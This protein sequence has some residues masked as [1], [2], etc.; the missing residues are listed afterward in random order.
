[1]KVIKIII[2]ILILSYVSTSSL[3]AGSFKCTGKIT[4]LLT[5]TSGIVQINGT[6]RDGITRMCN[7][8]FTWKGIEREICK[9][10][11]AIMQSARL[12]DKDVIVYYDTNENYTCMNL[13]D[14]GDT[15]AP[16]FVG[17]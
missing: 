4:T 15:P 11:L 6:W 1:M 17:S 8:K 7:V 10:W 9:Q 14:Y 12:Q 13:P 16:I 2:L 5:Y 3:H